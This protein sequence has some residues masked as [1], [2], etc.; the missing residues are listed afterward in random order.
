[1][2]REDDVNQNGISCEMSRILNIFEPA[3]NAIVNE[4]YK[5]SNI[6]KKNSRFV[7]F[8]NVIYLRAELSY[9]MMISHNQIKNSLHFLSIS[10]LL[11]L[12]LWILF[13][14]RGGYDIWIA[15]EYDLIVSKSRRQK[16]MK[17]VSQWL[18]FNFTFWQWVMA[19]FSDP[20]H[21][22]HFSSQLFSYSTL[23][24]TTFST[25]S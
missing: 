2:F 21:I 10:N 12:K 22:S 4:R 23:F 16:K 14:S 8:V 3:E 5:F 11:W 13:A 1:M 18:E 24:L 19:K 25:F 6:R 15:N 9:F 7:W 20:L 17:K